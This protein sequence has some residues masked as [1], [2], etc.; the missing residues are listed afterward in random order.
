M[1]HKLSSSDKV[2]I[3]GSSGLVGSAIKRKLLN[4]NFSIKK[5]NS[6]ILTP[7]KKELDLL[8]SLSLD[9]ILILSCSLIKEFKVLESIPFSPHALQNLVGLYFSVPQLVQ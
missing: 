8:D 7:S 6:N 1:K 5:N 2:F 9:S 3:A 4:Y